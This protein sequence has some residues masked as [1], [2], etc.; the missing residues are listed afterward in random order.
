MLSFQTSSARAPSLF[1]G[2]I[3]HLGC[4]NESRC[5]HENGR[6]NKAKCG[7]PGRIRTCTEL[8]LRE[9]PATNWATGA[10]VICRA[11]MRIGAYQRVHAR[12]RCAMGRGSNMRPAAYQTATQPAEL[13][14]RGVM[15]RKCNGTNLE[16]TPRDRTWDLLLT[17]QA[18]SP[19]ELCGRARNPQSDLSALLTVVPAAWL[20]H[21]ASAL[22]G[23][24]SSN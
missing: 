11:R 10:S 13:Q 22:R 7:A 24:R 14:R 19:T 3:L 6:Q 2:A 15:T 12:L 4:P 21:A 23:R 1:A 5:A 8:L 18:L 9:V 16:P 20:E 17:R